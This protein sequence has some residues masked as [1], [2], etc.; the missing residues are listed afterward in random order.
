[1]IFFGERTNQRLFSASA[2]F[3]SVKTKRSKK[4][5]FLHKIFCPKVAH[6][7]SLWISLRIILKE[8]FFYHARGRKLFSFYIAVVVWRFRANSFFSS[9]SLSLRLFLLPAREKVKEAS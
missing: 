8:I 6:K 2:F 7:N 9:S 4:A 1:M 5:A 3:A